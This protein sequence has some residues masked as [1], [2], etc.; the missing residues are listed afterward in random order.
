M[1]YIYIY[2]DEFQTNKIKNSFIY[3]LVHQE[4][5]QMIVVNKF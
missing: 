3:Q 5:H 2:M 4:M 1:L